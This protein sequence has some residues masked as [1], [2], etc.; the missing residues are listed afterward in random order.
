MTH[1]RGPKQ[2]SSGLT[3]AIAL[4]ATVHLQAYK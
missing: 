3:L 1:R 2:F 4:T